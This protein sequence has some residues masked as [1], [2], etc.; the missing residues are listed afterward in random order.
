MATLAGASLPM[1]WIYMLRSMATTRI[2]VDSEGI[3]YRDFRKDI[4]VPY[5]E[6][7]RIHFGWGSL[8]IKSEGKPTI[9]FGLHLDGMVELLARVKREIDLLGRDHVYDRKKLFKVYRKATRAAWVEAS[10]TRSKWEK[11]LHFFGLFVFS[12]GAGI[13]VLGGRPEGLWVYFWIMAAV[14][15]LGVWLAVVRLSRRIDRESDLEAF[16]VP[17]E[18]EGIYPSSLAWALLAGVVVCVVVA[19][20]GVA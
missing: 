10:I 13:L 7:S 11:L 12:V 17:E 8:K 5:S 3:R 6:I 9:S 2:I 16:T 14:F 20:L 1:L 18:P 4:M 19:V 15:P